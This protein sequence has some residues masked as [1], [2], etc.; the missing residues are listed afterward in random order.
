MTPEFI[1]AFTAFAALILSW[2]VLPG[3]AKETK[4]HRV[5]RTEAAPVVE[6]GLATA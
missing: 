3:G 4:A 5:A 2:I 6:P 1:A